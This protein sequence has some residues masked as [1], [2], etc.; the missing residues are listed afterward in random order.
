MSQARE[1][2]KI[3]ANFSGLK[4]KLLDAAHDAALKGHVRKKRTL[5][6]EKGKPELWMGEDN[7]SFVE[8]DLCGMQEQLDRFDDSVRK[9]SLR[10]N[11]TF[12]R[13][14]ATLDAMPPTSLLMFC[15]QSSEG[16][17]GSVERSASPGHA[18]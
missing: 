6:E 5:D 9:L 8:A 15:S 12:Q 13:S 10:Y 4:R 16:S 2:F 18:S 11:F 1:I 3:Y 14:V 17:V 7:N